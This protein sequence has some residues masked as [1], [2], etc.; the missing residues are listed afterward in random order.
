MKIETNADYL[1]ENDVTSESKFPPLMWTAVPMK[2]QNVST[3]GQSLFIAITMNSFIQLIQPSTFS[4]GLF[5]KFR[6][7]LI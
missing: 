3:M 6:L 7:L 4:L 1:V 5:Y 2:K